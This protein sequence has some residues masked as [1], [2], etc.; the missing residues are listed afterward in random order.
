M[1]HLKHNP[2]SLLLAAAALAFAPLAQAADDGLYKGSAWATLDVKKVQAAAAEVNLAKL[3]DCD[4]AV[5]DQ[6]SM[7]VV[8]EDGTA[9]VQDET[10]T[11]VLTEKGKRNNNTINL[12]FMTPYSTAE[13]TLLEVIRPSGEIVLVD[14]A[15]NSKESIDDSQMEMNIYDPNSKVLRVNIPQLEIGDI[16]HSVVRSTVTRPFIPGE[17]AEDFMFEGV[18]FVRHLALEVRMPSDKPLKQVVLRDEIPGT[19]GATTTTE[20]NSTVY[21]W[22]VNKVPRMFDEPA[23]PPYQEVLQHLSI[24]TTPDWSVVSRWYWDLSK[25]HLDAITPEMKKQVA[26]LTAGAATDMDRIKSVFYFVS[27]KI[28]YMGITPE[29]DRPGFEPHDVRITY[30]KKYGVCRDKAALL[31]SLLRAAGQ[32]AYPVLVSVG[33]KK[34]PQVPNPFFN[35]AI[36]GVELRKGEYVLMDP[37]DENTRDLLPTYEGNQSFLACRPDGDNLRLSPVDPPEKSMMR[38]ATTGT[39]DAAGALVARSEMSFDGVNDNEYRQ[40]FAQMKPDDRRRFFEA[41]LKHALPGATLR[42][43]TITPEN[44]LDTSVP[45]RAVIE[46]SAGNTT[47]FGEGNAV[48][49]VPWVGKDLGIVNFILGGTGLEKRRF[50]METFVACGLHED[51]SLR[52]AASFTGAVS[53]PTCVPQDDE[54]ASYHREYSFKDGVL[55]CSRDV[56]LK[57]VEFSPAQYLRLKRSLKEIQ[58]DDRKSPV[59]ATSDVKGEAAVAKPDSGA[60]APVE[61]DSRVLEESIDLQVKDAH[62]AV[63]KVRVVKEILN[64]SGKK[65]ESEIKI[66]YNPSVA[67]A[68]LIH[69]VVTSKAGRRQEIAKEEINVMDAGW[70]AAAKRYTGG[71]ILVANLPGVDVGSTIEVEYELAFHDKAFLSGFQAFQE[72]DELVQ[73]AFQVTAPEG[74]ALRTLDR[75]PAGI[76]TA[77]SKVADGTRVMTWKASNVKAMPAEYALPP[78]WLYEAGV[79]F[80]VG[81]PSA[82]LSDLQRALLDRSGHSVKAQELA[83]KLTTSA[84]T[85]LDAARAIRDYVSSSIRSA[86]PSFTDLPLSQLSDADTTLADG[87]GHEADRGILLHAMLSAAGFKPEFVLGSPDPAISVLS[88][89]A[90]KFPLPNEFQAV[91]VKVQMGDDTYYFNDTDQYARLGATPHEGRLAI[92]LSDQTYGTVTPARGAENRGATTY[93]IAL[94]GAG[95]VRMEILR[96]YS[97]AAYGKMNKFFSELTPEERRRYYQE[98][99]SKVAQGARPV[100]DLK[101]DFGAYPGLE[102]FTV[103]IDHYAVVD[104]RYLYLDLPYSLNLYPTFTDR[105]TLPLFIKD[106]RLETIRAEI[107]LP[108]EFRH[109][110]IAPRSQNLTAPDG[111][112]GVRVS[113]GVSGGTWSVTQELSAMPS[114]VAPQDYGALLSIESIL[115]NKSSRLLLLE[116]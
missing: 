55:A 76:V 71:R 110:V 79:A 100:G 112:G 7:R 86:G 53:M 8:H 113:A 72:G 98:A 54:C 109:V 9:E 81:D 103:E 69:A 16:V 63:F 26:D 21:R 32:N 84:K 116:H 68:R 52:L 23:M 45:V 25:P 42:S 83:R 35:H 12:G 24:S 28:R 67:D 46:F 51:V 20:G 91:L 18:G 101:T 97:G 59:L 82:Y 108:A 31:V 111:A 99:V 15:A 104:G 66:D 95:K 89:V 10:F 85:K 93:R 105:H 13:V 102:R 40:A 80:F 4:E 57:T 106:D 39:I 19:V 96:E 38:I 44:I 27:K 58:Y 33:W 29:K 11:K 37:T 90:T 74:L 77:A 30:D 94:D 1:T 61:S 60:V 43:L 115:E 88:D 107:G 56:R 78:G 3:P 65:K 75:G 17:Y 41:N 114:V 87:Y 50:P 92:N 47:A 36:V 2:L 14:V 5:V 6:R 73:K 48:V 34:D 22:E 49:N 64:Y 62:T 70:N